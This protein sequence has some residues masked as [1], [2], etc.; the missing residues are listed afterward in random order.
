M[1][2]EVFVA[3]YVGHLIGDQWVQT[4]GQ[5]VAKDQPGWSGRMACAGH[6][7]GH[8]IS[9]ALALNILF[10]VTGWWPNDWRLAVGLAISAV[11]HY[12]IDRRSPLLRVARWV[13]RLPYVAAVTV[14]RSPG[15]AAQ[16]T[17]PGTALFHLDQ[18][19]HLLFIFVAAL[20][21]AA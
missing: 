6:V 21:V 17:G 20:V 15:G 1:I 8:T 16:P 11:S 9:T 7:L 3:A 19:A 5:A 2:A 12:V 13:G 18:S 10:L 14:V 4:D